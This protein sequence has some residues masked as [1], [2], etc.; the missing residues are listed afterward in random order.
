MTGQGKVRGGVRG[1]AAVSGRIY[2]S[3]G[4]YIQYILDPK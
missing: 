4:G 2:V 1:K 3:I